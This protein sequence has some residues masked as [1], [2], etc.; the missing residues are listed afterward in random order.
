M[1]LPKAI[2]QNPQ[3]SKV[4]YQDGKVFAYRDGEVWELQKKTVW[5][6]HP[7]LLKVNDADRLEYY[8]KNC[9][10]KLGWLRSKIA[11]ERK[12]SSLRK[13]FRIN[14]KRHCKMITWI[15]DRIHELRGTMRYPYLLPEN[16]PTHTHENP[17]VQSIVVTHRIARDYDYPGKEHLEPLVEQ[18]N[19]RAKQTHEAYKRAYAD[20]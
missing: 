4:F 12:S 18:D 15:E 1:T 3:I 17:A 20:I 14:I 9:N 10:R 13:H 2:Q 7:N 11:D 6:P 8:L 5:T 19:L 16:S